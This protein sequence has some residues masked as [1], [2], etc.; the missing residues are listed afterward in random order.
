MNDPRTSDWNEL[1][2]M[3]QA[4]AAAVSFEEID[5]HLARERRR[6]RVI[7]FVELAGVGLGVAAAAWLTFFTPFRWLGA[8]VVVFTIVSAFAAVRMRREAVPSGAVDVLHSLKESIERED[9]IAEQLRMGRALSFVALFAIVM[10]T[11]TQLHRFHTLPTVGLAA[12]I[13]A[14]TY[15][16]AVLAWNLVL[17][18]RAHIRRTRLVYISERLN[19]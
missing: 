6:M 19:E 10:A 17:T 12:A 8:I 3:W 18:R 5:V 11:S 14:G 9:W 4:D 7:T 16:I 2:K 1:S 15:V 13:A